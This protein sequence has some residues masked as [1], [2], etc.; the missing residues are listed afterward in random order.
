[1]VPHLLKNLLIRDGK[2]FKKKINSIIINEPPYS[3]LLRKSR[4]TNGF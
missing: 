2:I 4:V 1:M 3:S